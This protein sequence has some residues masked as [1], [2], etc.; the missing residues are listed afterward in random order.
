MLEQGSDLVNRKIIS[1]AQKIESADIK[2]SESRKAALQQELIN[3]KQKYQNQV[4]QHRDS[5]LSLRKVIDF[6]SLTLKDPFISEGCIEIKIELNFS[7][8]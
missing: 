7:L 5:E 8:N 2:N 6:C 4:V 1:D 3:L